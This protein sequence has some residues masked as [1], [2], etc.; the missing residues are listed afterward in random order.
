MV[1]ELYVLKGSV[2]ERLDLST[3]SGITLSYK[4]NIFSD[5]SSITASF[6]Y[7]FK[8]PMTA[9]NRRILDSIE[10]VR[11][12]SSVSH[13]K[14]KGVFMQNGI[15]LFEN[16][17]LYIDSVD[18][19][20]N[21]IMT[22]GD[23]IV[24]GDIKDD[25]LKLNELTYFDGEVSWSDLEGTISSFT[26]TNKV[27]NNVVYNAGVKIYNFK[28]D[29]R[30]N[31]YRK[32]L[33]IV[34]FVP[35]VP[36]RAILQAIT[37]KYGINF[38]FVKLVYPGNWTDDEDRFDCVNKGVIP[39]VN[40][41]MS[42]KQYAE[43]LASFS[44]VRFSKDGPVDYNGKEFKNLISFTACSMGNSTGALL[45]GNGYIYAAAPINGYNSGIYDGFTL[46]DGCKF[47]ITGCFRAKF[48]D[49]TYGTPKMTLC[50]SKYEGW[51]EQEQVMKYSWTD[52]VEVA[53]KR[54]DGETDLWEFDFRD[55][56]S[57][58]PIEYTE[59]VNGGGTYMFW[60]SNTITSL[61]LVQKIDILPLEVGDDS[62]FI[63]KTNP[64]E[65]MP[66]TSVID[67][68]KSLFYMTG[69]FPVFKNGTLYAYDYDVFKENIKKGIVYQWN[70]KLTTSL[71]QL[72]SKTSFIVSDYAKRNY[73]A[74]STDNT[75]KD[76]ESDSKDVYANGLQSFYLSSQ[77]IATKEKTIIKLPWAPPYLLN[78]E[79]PNEDTGST[80]KSWVLNK[81]ADSASLSSNKVKYTSPK[82][83]LGIIIQREISHIDYGGNH[84]D[85]GKVMSLRIWNDFA[86]VLST[87]S[88]Q[89]LRSVIDKPIIVTENFELDE[90]DLRDLDFS[91]PVY[92]EKYNAFFAIVSLTRDSKGIC[93]TELIKLPSE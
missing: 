71:S 47:K 67:F 38:D 16:A 91:I 86:K 51:D 21:C 57:S 24:F 52:I 84:I 29:S 10:D 27:I 62:A 42:S 53:G 33:S 23:A 37:N 3:P 22:W 39:L 48:S 54:V 76:S 78:R 56:L 82:P 40:H 93:K 25:G 28:Y 14:L 43:Y 72:P 30:I 83:A 89:Y 68:L 2:L 59:P 80:I 20:Y 17:N 34:P 6:A 11:A 36:V 74:M 8:L 7:T 4:S 64:K 70:K 45:P 58:A 46:R 41:Q 61:S 79:F 60:F 90:F 13:K 50:F 26:N 65:C 31:Q 77:L 12:S 63:G 44:G 49:Y 85:D 19:V 5:L 18:T 35:V 73:Y 81:D 9:N 55:T 32:E 69:T 88:I 75:E 15:P 66:E 87:P 92:L 1:E